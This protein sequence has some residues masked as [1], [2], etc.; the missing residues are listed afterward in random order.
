MKR[1]IAVA[2]TAAVLGA[3]ALAGCAGHATYKPPAAK[4][5]R[6]AT[7]T[8]YFVVPTPTPTSGMDWAMTMDGDHAKLAYGPAQAGDARLTLACAKGSGKLSMSRMVPAEQAATPA[9][10]SL[11][12]GSARG[13]W[14]ATATPAADQ[15]GKTELKVETSTSDPAIDAFQ[16]NGWVAAILSD[17]KTEGMAP[18]PGDTSV[19]RFFDFCG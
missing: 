15:A 8:S 19:R 13:H 2:Q 17:G 7:S 5:L 1:V 10:L 6:P 16:R 3:A 14:L 9:V 4:L 12:S 11:A 18:H